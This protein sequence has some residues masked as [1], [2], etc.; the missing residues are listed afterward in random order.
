MNP[1][2]K[3]SRLREVHDQLREF[4]QVWARKEA[5]DPDAGRRL[6]EEVILLN[7]RRYFECIPIYRRWVEESGQGEDVGLETIKTDLMSTD[8]VFKSYNPE[9][10]DLKDFG[11]MTR[12]LGEIYHERLEAPHDGL[13]TVGDW[14][15]YLET[16]GVQVLFSSGTSG[17]FSFVPRDEYTWNS[18]MNNSFN[19]LS[20]M[21]LEKGFVMGQEFSAFVLG[22]R[23]GRLGIQL[24][25]QLIGN[26]AAESHF[27]YETEIIP[28]AIRILRRGPKDEQEMKLLLRFK[29]LT[30]DREEENYRRLMDAMAGTAATGR[31]VV[32]FGAP[33]QV[34]KMCELVLASGRKVSLPPQSMIVFGGGWK[35]FE[36]EKIER[37]VLVRMIGNTFGVPKDLIMEGYS[38]SEMNGA[39]LRCTGDRYHLPPL[40]EPV[41]LDE[42]LSPMA[43]R[44]LRGIFGFLDP[45][46]VSYPGFIISGDL[47]HLVDEACPCGLSGPAL[48]GE[49]T[50]APGRE[51]K[52]CGGVMATVRA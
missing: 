48:V 1:D 12:W 31:S 4:T 26:F 16:C 22:F 24:V 52:G 6:R 30:V 50:R 34:K 14:V 10:M 29:D 44:D 9:W 37:D 35:S 28:D 49:V 8:D 45:F 40:I 21:L 2:A 27:L 43:G 18:L 51:V 47:V 5:V 7:H 19:Y 11:A 39:F 42:S 23:G 36:G 13:G 17:L 38:M 25:G 20:F 33:F 3:M 41:I 46:A 15:A 32:L